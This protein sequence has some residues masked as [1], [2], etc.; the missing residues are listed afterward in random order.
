[1]PD[2]R[3]GTLYLVRPDWPG[4]SPDGVVEQFEH[5]RS[6]FDVAAELARLAG[7]D[8]RARRIEEVA[9][10]AYGRE[11]HKLNREDIQELLVLL[12]HLEDKLIG[13]VVDKDWKIRP[14]QLPELRKRTKT[15]E[16]EER[17]GNDAL[18]G[19]AEGMIRIGSARY[20]LNRA[21]DQHLEI[22]ME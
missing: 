2:Y 5:G 7:E 19:V 12:D 3:F 6:H 14:D 10:R 21:K 9:L 4:N 16:L 1:M 18:A 8:E 11:P 17:R 15:L 20:I 22:G 13:K